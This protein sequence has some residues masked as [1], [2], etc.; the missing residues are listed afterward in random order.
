M[1]FKNYYQVLGVTSS[2][3]PDEIKSAYRYLA[4]RYHPDK[5]SD[6][7]GAFFSDYMILVNE[8]YE[9]LSNKTTKHE[10]DNREFGFTANEN[11]D[12]ATSTSVKKNISTN[13]ASLA[14]ADADAEP[15]SVQIKKNIFKILLIVLPLLAGVSLAT[16]W[17]TKSKFEKQPPAAQY[18]TQELAQKDTNLLQ[19]AQELKN[20]LALADGYE[21]RLQE[22][23]STAQLPTQAA[24]ANRAE[25]TVNRQDEKSL[26]A[27]KNT[28]QTASIVPILGKDPT[29]AEP[30]RGTKRLY[31]GASPYTE[32]YGEGRFDAGSYNTLSIKNMQN[33]DAIVLLVD[34]SNDDVLRNEFVEAGTTY[35]IKKIPNGNY[36]IKVILGKDFNPNKTILGGSLQGGFEQGLKLKKF[37]GENAI[38]RMQQSFENGK[39]DYTSVQVR[40]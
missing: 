19:I 37:E 39:L 12:V 11:I 7:N 32:K 8:A 33:L 6:S 21:K 28:R 34:A 29:D 23:L 22:T 16:Y 3:S 1:S 26:Y 14:F 30:T 9:I 2:A 18:T 38:I 15:Q 5:T 24:A 4:K 25:L 31:N 13:A 27:P 20:D 40:I 17:Y 10:Y 36:Y 35:E